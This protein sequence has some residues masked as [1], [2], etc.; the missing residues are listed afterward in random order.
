LISSC[1]I[2]ASLHH[3]AAHAHIQGSACSGRLLKNQDRS[4][5]IRSGIKTFLLEANFAMVQNIE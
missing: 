1:N 2:S 5:D 4:M 3:P